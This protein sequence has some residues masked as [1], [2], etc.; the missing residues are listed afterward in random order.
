[1]S[2]PAFFEHAPS[3]RLRDPLAQFLGSAKDGILQYSYGEIV[4]LAGHSC[5]TVAGAYLMTINALK[6][7]YGEDLPERGAIKVAFRD[8]QQD[9]VTGVI[10][11]VVSF[12]TGA[13]TDTGFKG[14]RGKFDRRNLLSFDNSIEG[15]IKFQRVDTGAEV[16][17]DFNSSIVPA[18]PGLFPSLLHALEGPAT[19]QEKQDFAAAWQGRVEQILALADDPGLVVLI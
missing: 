13:T 1:M 7:L 19:E 15:L 4:K 16:T 9:G 6:K 14:L 18:P 17:V 8:S 5:P 2:F 12:I 3:I 10:A 11:N